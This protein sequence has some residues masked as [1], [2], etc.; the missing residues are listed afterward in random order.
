M[1]AFIFLLLRLIT[2]MFYF[3]IVLYN[4]SIKFKIW[5]PVNSIHIMV[6]K[7]ILFPI[8]PLGDVRK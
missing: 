7:Q 6:I 2:F 4:L 8:D 1:E 5:K 3:I